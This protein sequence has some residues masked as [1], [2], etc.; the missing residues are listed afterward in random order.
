MRS[1]SGAIQPSLFLCSRPRSLLFLQ[2]RSRPFCGRRPRR[3]GVYASSYYTSCLLTTE[4]IS[5]RVVD[6][7]DRLPSDD[8][9]S[10]SSRQRRELCQPRVAAH[11]CA[12]VVGGAPWVEGCTPRRSS[13]RRGFKPARGRDRSSEP[14]F[15]S[16]SA[17]HLTP[18][19]D[20]ASACRRL[21]VKQSARPS[22]GERSPTQGC[23]GGSATSLHP[24]LTYFT[25]LA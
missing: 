12:A 24:G 17:A 7:P 13:P 2:G 18:R 11:R 3:P 19:V 21:T 20:A 23:A 5:P 14:R 22:G 4:A 16:L 10:V 1:N 8:A 9:G 15:V 25:P 6:M